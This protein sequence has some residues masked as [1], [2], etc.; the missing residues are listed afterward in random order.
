MIQ[1][2]E[3]HTVFC[4]DPQTETEVVKRPVHVRHFIFTKGKCNA[5]HRGG[6]I[7]AN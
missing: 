4:F 3:A 1:F 7:A 5:R 2:F 6:L